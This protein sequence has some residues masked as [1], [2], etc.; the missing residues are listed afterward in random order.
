M[1]NTSIRKLYIDL[2]GVLIGKMR[3]GDINC[4]IAKYVEGFLKYS[5]ASFEC[6][7]LS[8]HCK[9]GDK[10]RIMQ[11]LSV[12]ADESILSLAKDIKPTFWRTLKTEAIDFQSDFYWLDDRPLEVELNTLRERKVYDR[13]IPVDTRRNP[14]DLKRVL[15]ILNSLNTIS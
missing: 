13:F 12:Y 4:T 2:D 8:T 6:F 5:L 1:N 10:K 14:D 9:N 3:P 7:W 15:K 11:Q